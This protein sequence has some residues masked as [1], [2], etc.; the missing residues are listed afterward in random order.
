MTWRRYHLDTTLRRAIEDGKILQE[1]LADS[2][3]DL[4]SKESTEQRMLNLW[5]YWQ[6]KVLPRLAPAHRKELVAL[7]MALPQP[8]TIGIL[9]CH[10]ADRLA[11]Q[12]KYIKWLL[13]QSANRKP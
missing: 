3:I 10:M 13:D 4:P 1:L 2:C 8:S 6:S 12:T 7:R 11:R 5:R 9:R